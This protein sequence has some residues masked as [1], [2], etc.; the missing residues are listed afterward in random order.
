MPLK[1]AGSNWVDGDRFHNR[2]AELESLAGRAS[3]GTHT[4]ITAPRRMGKT[5]L[6]REFLR[7][8]KHNGKFETIFVDLEDATDA[9]DAIAELAAQ[10][11]KSAGGW[12]RIKSGF[13]RLVSGIPG[14]IDSL[15]VSELRIQF[16]AQINAGNRWRKG[17]EVFAA[18]AGS[19]RPVIL[20]IDELPIL[21]N[22][23]L[24]ERTDGTTSDGKKDVDELLSWLRKNGQTHRG[25]ITLVLSGSVGLEPILRRAGLSAQI[26]IFEPFALRPWTE[27]VALGCL[28]SLAT[29]YGVDL[30]ESVKREICRRLRFLVPH[31]VQQF[32]DHLHEFLRRAGRNEARLDDV[33]HVYRNELLSVRGQMNNEHYQSRLRLVL[34]D[35]EYPAAL[36]LLTEAS[37][38]DG[39]LSDESISLYRERYGTEA[40]PGSSFLNLEEILYLL[41]HDGYLVRKE[42]GYSFLSGFLQD[43]W[44]ARNGRNFVPIAE[45]IS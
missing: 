17:D 44:Q 14:S 43:W 22:R 18:L 4:L 34:N 15:G 6:V 2:D 7:R 30:P 37:I 9:A 32:F 45:R 29:N 5:S 12:A 42:D 8:A 36:E 23:L 24:M 13:R 38:A 21:V 1:K 10:T 39:L 33:E 40:G 19:N 20:A 26:N 3:D 35:S 25:K 16:R 27:S 41:E 31:H 11:W 28:S